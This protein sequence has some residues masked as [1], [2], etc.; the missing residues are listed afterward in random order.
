MTDERFIRLRASPAEM[1]QFWADGWRHFGVFFF[2]YR[3]VIHGR[4]RFTVLP[5]R[6][7]LRR[8]AL[9]RSHKRILAKNRDVRILIRPACIDDAKEALF[10]KHRV[11]FKENAPSSLDDFLSPRPDSIPCLNLELC[12]YLGDRLVGVTFLDVGETAIS[13]VYAMFDPFETR[14]SLGIM[15]MLQSIRLSREREYAYYYPGYAYR[16]PFAYD[17]KKRFVGLEYL[18]WGTGWKPYPRERLDTDK[19]I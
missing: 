4:K 11:R 18:E 5:L 8:F 17:Y 13:A 3:N 14:R 6:V 9:G 12:L 16:E 19:K 15:M 1:D 10:S 7:D 2:R